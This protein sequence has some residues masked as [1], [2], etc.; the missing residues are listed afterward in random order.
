MKRIRSV[1]FGPL[2]SGLLVGLSLVP[3]PTASTSG[4]RAL[5]GPTFTVNTYVD[6]ADANPGDGKCDSAPPNLVCTLRAAIMEANKTKDATIRL[7]ADTYS[8]TSIGAGE[9]NGATGDLDIK[10]DMTITSVGADPVIIDGNGGATGDRVLHILSGKVALSNL[11]IQHGLGVGGGIFIEAG[12]LVTINNSTVSENILNFPQGGGSGI[13]NKGTLTL[14]G[15]AV[16]NNHSTLLG[17]SNG[18]VTAGGGIFNTGTLAVSDSTVSGNRACD[19]GGIVNG[20][21]M[22]LT[23]TT[24]SGNLAGR[25]GGG[26]V[27]GGTMTLINSTISKNTGGAAAGLCQSIVGVLVVFVVS[28]IDGGGIANAGTATLVNCTIS[29]NAS[30]SMGGGIAN[31][32]TG[33]LIIPDPSKP[34]HPQSSKGMLSLFNVTIAYNTSGLG[35]KNLGLQLKNGGTLGW[36]DKGGG[37][38][39]D[40]VSTVTFKNTIISNNTHDSANKPW[41]LWT[42]VGASFTGQKQSLST[43]ART[44]TRLDLFLVGADGKVY[45]NSSDRK[46]R[47]GQWNQWT[48]IDQAFTA[49][50]ESTITNVMRTGGHL[51][52]FV[53][54]NDGRIYTNSADEKINSGR[55]NRWIAIGNSSNTVPKQSPITAVSRTADRVDLFVV[56]NDGRIYTNFYDTKVSSGRWN[57]WAPQDPIFKV[58]PESVV[59]AVARTPDRLDLFVVG[60]DGMIYTNFFDA[61][62]NK[63]NQWIPGNPVFIALPQ[64]VV[65]AVA[66]TAER[67][68]LFVVGPDGGVYRSF[69]DAMFN[70]GEWSQ[71]SR[72]GDSFS[73]PMQS[74]VSAVAR[75]SQQVDLFVAGNDGGVYNLALAEVGEGGAIY[76]PAGEEQLKDDKQVWNRIGSMF[77]VAPRTS[78]AVAVLEQDLH[79][80][81]NGFDNGIF[82][83]WWGPKPDDCSAVKALASEDYNLI[84]DL[85]GCKLVGLSLRN[86]TGVSPALGPLQDN[87]GPTHTHALL[88][89]SPAIDAGNSRGCTDNWGAPLQTDQR[90]FIRPVGGGR[91]P[92][93]RKICDIGAHE[94][95][96]TGPCPPPEITCPANKTLFTGGS[97]MAVF[98]EKATAKSPCDPSPMITSTPPLPATFNFVGENLVTFTAKDTSG[99]TSSCTTKVTVVMNQPPTANAG[100]DQ[101]IV[102]N[103]QIITVTLTAAG[104]ADPDGQAI[105]Y[106]WQQISGPAVALNNPTSATPTFSQS[107]DYQWREFRLTI[108]DPCGMTATDTVRVFA[109]Y[110]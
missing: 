76:D 2:L 91:D 22:T 75:N 78:I 84:S 66:R 69:S 5:A 60:S 58:M 64:S 45:N 18:D 15:S 3:N 108:T 87:G 89:G 53:V 103:S 49:S 70:D 71:W 46:V 13:Y 79:L 90:G 55:W 73:A 35:A 100:P 63:W 31:G 12:S 33:Y 44:T 19:G 38:S 7:P 47:N 95:N 65:T 4:L 36:G 30:S 105:T 80:F 26:I 57:Q 21:T 97:C 106:L 1:A 52:L 61:K 23:N 110:P 85:T 8:L 81:T 74:V 17:A 41:Q 107:T 99:N 93:V 39:N 77:T 56:G 48:P 101:T 82:Q 25:S 43:A 40:D 88:A 104:S 37:I 62:A 10:S 86:K 29:G 24:V 92:E 14:D 98:N 83:A 20:G 59:T 11:T 54:G 9:E 102:T 67:L 42:R 27:N 6:F 28:S 72:M 68:D 51:D 96:S 16:K 50:A 94:Y 32:L 34:I 109:R